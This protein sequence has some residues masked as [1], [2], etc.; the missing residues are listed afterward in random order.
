MTMGGDHY[1]MLYP[2]DKEL[3]TVWISC[4]FFEDSPV[5]MAGCNSQ[6]NISYGIV[7][8]EGARIGEPRMDDG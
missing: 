4:L 8:H 3:L 5:D 7:F 1:Y 2:D 6:T